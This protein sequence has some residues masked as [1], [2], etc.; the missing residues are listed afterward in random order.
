MYAIRLPM[1]SSGATP[2]TWM[3]TAGRIMFSMNALSSRSFDRQTRT[4]RQTTNECVLCLTH[5]KGMW[6]YA[7]VPFLIYPLLLLL[8]H[9]LCSFRANISTDC[10]L[11]STARRVSKKTCSS[12]WSQSVGGSHCEHVLNFHLWFE[13]WKW[14]IVF[15]W[16]SYMLLLIIFTKC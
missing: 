12:R 3:D 2:V 4:H 14:G 15:I 16:N 11:F 8:S 6:H 13:C 1:Q 10:F 5:A 7:S 9:H